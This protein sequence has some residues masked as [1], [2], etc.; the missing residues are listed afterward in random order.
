MRYRTVSRIYVNGGGGS[1]AET[2][3]ALGVPL[4]KASN[5]SS[6][7]KDSEDKYESANRA[8]E[9]LALIILAFL[10]SS[11]VPSSRAFSQVVP[12]SAPATAQAGQAQGRSL[13]R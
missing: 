11:Q 10:S 13:P 3:S 12:R 1:D 6:G 5:V 4:R 2:S 8:P 7:A 9:L